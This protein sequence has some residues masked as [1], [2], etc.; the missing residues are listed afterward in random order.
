MSQIA[1]GTLGG[2]D[3]WQAIHRPEDNAPGQA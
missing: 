3:W 1:D 2:G